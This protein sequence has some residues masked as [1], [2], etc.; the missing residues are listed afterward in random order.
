MH[1]FPSHM[2]IDIPVSFTNPFRYHP[3][4]LVSIAA[5]EVMKLADEADA[6]FSEGKMM[7]VL[8][9]SDSEGGYGYLAGFSGSIN[10]KSNVNGFVPPIFDLLAADGDFFTIIERGDNVFNFLVVY[11]A[12]GIAYRRV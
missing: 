3:H 2:D 1:R 11:K 4:P 7:G 12:V 8:I 9:V 5:D 10:G 6:D